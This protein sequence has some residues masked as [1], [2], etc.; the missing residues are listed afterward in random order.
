MKHICKII[1]PICLLFI[2]ASPSYSQLKMG[3]KFGLSVPNED[4]GKVTANIQDSVGNKK[5]VSQTFLDE[6]KS[7]YH[8]IATGYISL[9]KDLDLIASI[10]IN[11]F[12]QS[13]IQ[14]RDFPDT[15]KIIATLLNSLN[16][17]P[18]EV[19]VKYKITEIGFISLY[20][21]GNLSYN[22][23]STSSDV[24][25]NVGFTSFGFPIQSS[26]TDRRL[27]YGIGA[28]LQLD[29]SVVKAFL[30][31]KANGAN[32]IGKSDGETTKN[33]YTISAGVI[34]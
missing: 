11:R 32:L 29:F 24:D 4:L 14:V 15:T 9:G 10:G 23:I 12:T 34:L 6:S 7:G 3:V 28:G 33:F 19:G 21:V 13:K 8:L 2:M 25:Y 18:I 31:F 22:Y 27:G 5:N 26:Q 1:L 16:V 17:I 30:E 20:T